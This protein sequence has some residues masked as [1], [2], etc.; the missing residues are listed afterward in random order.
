[1]GAGFD[2]NGERSLGNLIV[3][4]LLVVRVA[5]L[6]FGARSYA[7]AA[8]D[9]VFGRGPLGIA[10]GASGGRHDAVIYGNTDICSVDTRLDIQLM[11]NRLSER[12]V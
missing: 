6:N 4:Y 12:F 7:L 10:N 9:R 8:L 2:R 11:D 1:V 5:N 3:C